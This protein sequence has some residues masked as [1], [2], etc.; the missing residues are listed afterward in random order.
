M[1]KE[2]ISVSSAAYFPIC[3]L[4]ALGPLF[5]DPRTQ[6]DNYDEEPTFLEYDYENSGWTAQRNLRL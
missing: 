4:I 5:D 2:R 1:L 3:V 6:D